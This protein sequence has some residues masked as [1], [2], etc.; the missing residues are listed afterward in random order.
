[1][2]WGA[3][4]S[5]FRVAGTT[6]REATDDDRPVDIRTP[7]PCRADSHYSTVGSAQIPEPPRVYTGAHRC[8][9]SGILSPRV[10]ALRGDTEFKGD[11]EI[12]KDTSIP[13]PIKMGGLHGGDVMKRF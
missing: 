9:R 10:P 11:Q 3:C 2:N 7:S 8:A 4:H 12:F 6:S 1:M 13:P 5:K